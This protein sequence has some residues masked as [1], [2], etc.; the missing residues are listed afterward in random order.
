MDSQMMLQIT[1]AAVLS[2]L[3]ILMIVIVLN[4]I[5]VTRYNLKH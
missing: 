2:V 5:K 3:D 4:D 1:L